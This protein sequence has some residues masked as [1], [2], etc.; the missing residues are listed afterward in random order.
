MYI[1]MVRW[2]PFGVRL[3]S[4]NK[5]SRLCGLKVRDGSIMIQSAL[6]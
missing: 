2:E 1:R 6:T 4:P 3:S 5:W